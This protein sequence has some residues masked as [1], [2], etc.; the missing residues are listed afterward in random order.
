[1]SLTL[2]LGGARSGKSKFAQKLCENKEAVVLIATALPLDDEMEERIKRHRAERS[3]HWKTVEEPEDIFNAIRNSSYEDYII[4]DCLT[5]W[6]SNLLEKYTDEEVARIA[7]EIS[8]YSRGLKGEVIVIS[9]EVGLG[10]VP[11]YPLGR[12]YRDLLGRVNQIFAGN[13]NKVLFMIAGIPMEVKN[14]SK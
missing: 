12:R 1:M 8:A 6:V 10:I 11:E 4:V 7:E 9:N 13:A 5:M 3:S 2:I 14:E